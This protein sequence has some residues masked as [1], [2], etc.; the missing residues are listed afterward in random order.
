MRDVE[1]IGRGDAATRCPLIRY[2]SAGRYEG[3]RY[4]NE[5]VADVA[6]FFSDEPLVRLR[7]PTRRGP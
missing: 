7:R 5:E 3:Y 2:E 6:A 1:A 4:V